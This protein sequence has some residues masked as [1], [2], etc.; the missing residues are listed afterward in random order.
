MKDED[1]RRR[2]NAIGLWIFSGFHKNPDYW[3]RVSVEGVPPALRRRGSVA[4]R[5][6]ILAVAAIAL[7]YAVRV[8]EASQQCA[9]PIFEY[10]VPCMLHEVAT[11]EDLRF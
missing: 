10:T 6:L 2:E 11:G 5:L 4:K 8:A 3:E 7:F 1:R 9:F